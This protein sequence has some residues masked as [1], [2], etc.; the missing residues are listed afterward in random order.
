MDIDKL[1]N[2]DLENDHIKQDTHIDDVVLNI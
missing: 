1:M 2:Q